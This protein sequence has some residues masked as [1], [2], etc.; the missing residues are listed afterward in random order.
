[1]AA[2]GHEVIGIDSEETKL[3]RLRSG[4]I[5]FYEPGLEELLIDGLQSGRLTFTSSYSEAARFADL[6]FI[7]VGTPQM[8]G[9]FTADLSAVDAAIEELS[10]LVERPGIIVGKSTVPV[11]TAQRLRDRAQQL[12]P[13]GTE[14]DL[15]WNPEFLREGRAISDTSARIV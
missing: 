9:D 15:V 6:F 4:E 13:V 1:M 5:P 2:L 10:P 3:A 12:S 7:A 8:P 14:L 11:G